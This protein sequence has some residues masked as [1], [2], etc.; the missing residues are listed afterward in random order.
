MIPK[1]VKHVLPFFA[2]LVV[3]VPAAWAQKAVPVAATSNN[4]ILTSG[5]S[6]LTAGPGRAA[7]IRS[8]KYNGAEVLYV[9]SSNNNNDW[10]STFWPSPQAYWSA[11]CKSASPPNFQCNGP[12]AA[13]DA[14]TDVDNGGLI[15]ADTA[16]SYV[17]MADTATPK[18]GTAGGTGVRIRKTFWANSRDSSFS[19]QYTIFNASKAA[20]AFAPWEITR[21][22]GGGLSFYPTSMDTVRGVAGLRAMIKDT[23]GV[24]WFTYDSTS[25]PTSGVPKILAD[26]SGGWYAHVDKNRVLFIKKFYDTPLAKGAPLNTNEAE[27]ALYTAPAKTYQEMELQ[28]PFDTIGVAD[29]VNWTVKWL[30][31]KLPDSVTV[32]RNGPLLNFAAQM[33]NASSPIDS[34]SFLPVALYGNSRTP[35]FSMDY[36]DGRVRLSLSE[37]SAL[38]LSLVD[39]RGRELSRVYSGMLA[40]GSHDFLLNPA[41]PKG[42][43]WLILKHAGVSQALASK[44]LVRY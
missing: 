43:Y 26:G 41:L 21:F 9:D 34:A 19:Q 4:Y 28:G 15:A 23:L 37:A 40:E 10:G 2:A 39:S 12:P 38:S 35:F 18:S 7:R 30:V 22:A 44:M 11:T 13:V 32:G 1:S 42:V 33:I 24:T 3:V 6:V 25:I 31:R 20:I 8:L 36:S 17:G 14:A 16:L 27:C 29:S 5:A